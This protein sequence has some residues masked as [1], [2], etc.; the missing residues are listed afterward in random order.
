MKTITKKPKTITHDPLVEAR[1]RLFELKELQ[2]EARDEELRIR[3]YL[4]NFLH[5]GESGAKTVT[6]DGIKV[7]VTRNLN[8]S[9]D[10]PNA[11][12]FSKEHSDVALEVLK[13]KPTVSISGFKKNWDV[14]SE[15]CVVKPGP[16]TVEFQ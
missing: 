6:V 3:E 11:E 1:D 2:N 9:I 14:A 4:A 13:W 5:D 16:S 10:G 12:R 8:Y 7:T 15:Y